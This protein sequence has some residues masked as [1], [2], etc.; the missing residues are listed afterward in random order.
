MNLSLE[1]LN[2]KSSLGFP[3]V[4]SN[5]KVSQTADQLPKSQRQHCSLSWLNTK[6]YFAFPNLLY[7]DIFD[8][9]DDQIN[10]ALFLSGKYLIDE[11]SVIN[12]FIPS[13]DD[14]ED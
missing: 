7:Y 10:V 5:P 8:S 11:E 3:F 2:D 12:Q 1:I 6:V 13:L 9:H 4:S 14:D